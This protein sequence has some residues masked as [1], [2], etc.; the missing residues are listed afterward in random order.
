MRRWL[1]GLA[2]TL[3]AALPAQAEPRVWV[4]RDA[5]SEVVLF[6]SVHVLPPGLA[7]RPAALDAAL[8]RAD[9]LWFELPV[10]AATEQETARLAAS[11]GLLPTGQS[12]FGLLPPGD[13][14]RLVRLAQTYGVD[15]VVLDRLKPWLAEV[16]LASALYGRSGADTANGV[17]QVVSARA[18]ATVQRRAF[19]TPALQLGLFDEAPLADQIA[20]LS[21]TLRELDTEPDTYDALVKAWLD[22]DT[23]G[24][25]EETE[26]LRKASPELYRRLVRDRN[27]AWVRTL[28]ARLKGRGRTVVVVGTGHLVGEDGLPA[29]LRALGYS[30]EGP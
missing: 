6:G 19:E 7:W 1:L 21:E 15:R 26:S 13:A 30:V 28:D 27:A 12:L 23:A 25:A 16:A 20:S 2:A 9:D 29:R 14:A 11:M 24:L 22:G 5:D 17:E 18:P 4:V 3:L 8:A 10:D